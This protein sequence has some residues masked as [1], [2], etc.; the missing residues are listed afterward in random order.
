MKGSIHSDQRCPEC[1]KP[2]RHTEPRG[3]WCEDHPAFMPT[4]F[5]VLFGKL[6]K[7]FKSYDGAYRFLT[8]LRYE[9][10]KGTFDARDYQ[11]NTPLAVDNLIRDFIAVNSE[12]K[13]VKKYE[14]RLR[15]AAEAWQ[16]KNIKTI[17]KKDIQLLLNSLIR[18]GYSH[19]YRYDINESIK[20]FFKWVHDCDS[21]IPMP[22]FVSMKLIMN[23]RKI[24]K[25]ED[26][27]RV[28]DKIYEMTHADNPRVYVACL[29]LATYIIVR[30]NEL[31]TIRER[32]I[33]YDNGRILILSPK[34]GPPKYLYLLQEDI[35]LLRTLK[36]G[37]SNQYLFRH[38]K[39]SGAASPGDQFS[40]DYLYQVWRRACKA[41]DP[42]VKGVSLYPGT[43]HSTEVDLRAK[44]RT[45]E[46]IWRA[47]GTRSNKAR[48]RYLQVTGDEL[49][50]LYADTRDNIV[51]LA[52]RKKTK[53]V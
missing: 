3:M 19:K 32:D 10:D 20:M 8:G 48:E 52:N 33:E 35:E 41:C 47:A 6:C 44:G 46:E 17:T 49:K 50:D 18:K 39:G 15:F 40:K 34:E 2:F 9:T 12:L 14:Q 42:E 31:R 53:V 28:L 30:P 24:I 27:V 21:S 7:R 37:F 13:S 1:H 4:R 29:F 43:R 51:D 25:K 36:P 5:K 22:K 16:G 26:Q 38:E 45:P 11:N 23:M